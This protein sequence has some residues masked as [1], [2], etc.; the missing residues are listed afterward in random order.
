[1]DAALRDVRTAGGAERRRWVWRTSDALLLRPYRP[2]VVR[3][4]SPARLEMFDRLLKEFEETIEPQ[5]QS[6]GE[7]VVHNDLNDHN[8]LQTDGAISGVIDLGDV[9][10]ERHCFSLGNTLYYMMLTLPVRQPFV[11]RHYLICNSWSM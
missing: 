5:L 6:A 2:S 8:T 9:C 10:L 7:G 1:M 11:F 4:Q 3:R